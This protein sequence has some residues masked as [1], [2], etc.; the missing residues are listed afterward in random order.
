MLFFSLLVELKWSI[1]KPR[2]SITAAAILVTGP[3]TRDRPPH[4][5]PVPST[6][7]LASPTTTSDSNYFPVGLARLFGSLPLPPKDLMTRGYEGDVSEIESVELSSRKGKRKAT[8]PLEIHCFPLNVQ[9]RTSDW[10]RERIPGDS[11]G[12]DVIIA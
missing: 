4:E 9:F 8:E 3:S 12:Y 10:P 6:S 5:L 2:E 1:Q 7:T 11:K